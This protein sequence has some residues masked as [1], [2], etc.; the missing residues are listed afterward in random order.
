[1]DVK[2]TPGNTLN[3]ELEWICD[4]CYDLDQS[5]DDLMTNLPKGVIFGH[6]NVCGILSK[7]DQLKINLYR[8]TRD[9]YRRCTIM[10]LKETFS[11]GSLGG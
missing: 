9:Y 2:K 3:S 6:I 5:T 11:N 10:A 8:T 7:L 1:L 4:N